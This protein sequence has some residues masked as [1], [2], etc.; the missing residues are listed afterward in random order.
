MMLMTT[1]WMTTEMMTDM[2]P[3]AIAV[4]RA[5]LAPRWRSAPAPVSR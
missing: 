5:P 3:N 4:L 1:I 2:T